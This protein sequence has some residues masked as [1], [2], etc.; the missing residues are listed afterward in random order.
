MSQG[1]LN[2]FKVKPFS[3]KDLSETYL[4]PGQTSFMKPFTEIVTG[5]WLL[6]ISEKSVFTDVCQGSK[7]LNWSLHLIMDICDVLRYLAP[8]SQ[9][10]K[11]ENNYGEALL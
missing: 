10:R 9:F 11:R 2:L 4:E 1:T 3:L 6:I 5:F 8:F 7:I